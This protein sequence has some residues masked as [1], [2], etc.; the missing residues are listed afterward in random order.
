MAFNV[1]RI[2]P[3]DLQPRKAVGIDLPFSGLILHT[4]LKMH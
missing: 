1:K 4:L 2:N 3:L